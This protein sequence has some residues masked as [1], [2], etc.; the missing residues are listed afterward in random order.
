MA[1]KLT[2]DRAYNELEKIFN[3]IEGN[4]VPLEQ[5]AKRIGRA[6]ELVQY[7]KEKLRDIEYDVDNMIDEEE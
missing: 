4:D 3:E 5:L 6:N 1:R 2:Y 7:C